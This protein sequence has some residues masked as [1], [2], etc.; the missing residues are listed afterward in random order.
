MDPMAE[1]QCGSQETASLNKD[2]QIIR[3]KILISGIVQGVGFRPFVYRIAQ[4]S[5]IKGWVLNSAAGVVID[6][7]ATEKQL[8][9]FIFELENNPPP[10]ARI[11]SIEKKRLE[12]LCGYPDFRIRLSDQV[13]EKRVLV[14]PDVAICRDCLADIKDR[15]DRHFNYPFTNCTNCGP[16]FTIVRDLP[17]DRAQTSMAAFPMCDECAAE[18]DS[19]EDRRFH[20]QPV[21]CPHCGPH[22]W[23]VNSRGDK[24]RGN[25]QDQFH[26]AI[27]SGQIVALRGLGGFHLICDAFD[28][29]AI[30]RLR[31]R[32]KRPAKPFAVMVRDIETLKKYCVVSEKEANLISGPAAPIVLLRL[33]AEANLPLSLAPG[34]QSLG[35][36]LP[37]TPLHCML[38]DDNTEMLIMTS[39]NKSNMPICK[40]NDEAFDQLSEIADVFLLHDREIVNRADD[41]VVRIIGSRLQYIRRSRGYVPLPIEIP[42]GE[43]KV[44]IMGAGG[45]MKNVFCL[46][47]GRQAFMSQHIGEMGTKEAL[48]NYQ[49]SCSNFQKLIDCSPSIVGYDMHPGYQ[50]SNYVERMD[51]LYKYPVQHHHAHLASCLA[52]ND[53][54]ETVIGVIMDG[55]GYGTDG[56]IWGFE[57]LTGNYN[58]FQ[59]HYHLQYIP[60]PGSDRAVRRNILTG[61]SWLRKAYD[62]DARELAR[63]LWPEHIQELQI[64][65]QMIKGNINS[66]LCSSAGR[67]FDA[68]S[69][70]NNICLENT[71]EGQA[72]VE[73]A[74]TILGMESENSSTDCYRYKITDD[75]IN[76][77]PM[78]RGIVEDIKQGTDRQHIVLKIHETLVS[79]IKDCVVQISEATDLKTVVLSGGVF[80]NLYLAE[81][82]PYELQKCGLKVFSH[83]Q[84]PANDG[85]LALGQAAIAYWR[86]KN[87][88]CGSTGTGF[89]DQR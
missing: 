74:E 87:H 55:T 83:C 21:A 8:A 34:L 22:I 38:F 69:A 20:A 24:L 47:K 30:E 52:D 61:Y 65:D 53:L 37:Y 56:R 85:G 4:E 10:L 17:Y 62:D 51:W 41:S 36:M 48:D 31:D 79:V 6:A 50:A 16:R 88:V 44:N 54:N 9:D 78:I 40:D 18:Y 77:E 42:A 80:Q 43:D 23:M 89:K 68:L 72:T 26:R 76:L 63:D 66:P 59:R 1:R 64:A 11:K 33:K 2:A 71:Y 57:L 28:Q 60:L 14:P 58:D 15:N 3:I 84:V 5:G 86:W 39:G 46:L 13:A 35:V 49:Y 75:E 32:K 27:N 45:E 19:P 7:E 25:W 81:R 82:V 12:N 29:N 70:I 73:M 67:L